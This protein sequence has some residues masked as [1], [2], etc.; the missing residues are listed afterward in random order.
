MNPDSF[1]LLTLQ[2]GQRLF[3]L[4]NF[5][6]RAQIAQRHRQKLSSGVSV[7][8]DCRLVDLQK[9]QRFGVVQPE[10]KRCGIEQFTIN[11]NLIGHGY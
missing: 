5:I 3:E 6:S 7:Q 10:R 2:T 4:F 11:L 8:F 1:H 9:L